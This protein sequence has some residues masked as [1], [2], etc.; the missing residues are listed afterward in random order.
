MTHLASPQFPMVIDNLEDKDGMIWNVSM[1]AWTNESTTPAPGTVAVVTDGVTIEGDGLSA[2][3]IRM[4]P[5]TGG[6]Q[7]Y[8]GGSFGVN[9]YG[10]IT[11]N[12]VKPSYQ[13]FGVQFQQLNQ[14]MANA[15]QNQVLA[16]NLSSTYE[17]LVS[18]QFSSFNTGSGVYG[19][20]VTGFY[21][22]SVTGVFAANSQGIRSVGIWQNT[23]LQTATPWG[24]N[25]ANANSSGTT[26]VSGSATF[27]CQAND[28]IQVWGMQSSGN[29]INATFTVAIAFVG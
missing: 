28:S 3:A 22:V 12:P 13:N 7:T 4:V 2:D 14:S 16:N 1:N 26:T 17:T 5:V 23:V 27:F 10:Q 20:A 18:P 24:N 15:S 11:S 9:T 25:Y 29:P 19:C 8:Y 21:S 6:S